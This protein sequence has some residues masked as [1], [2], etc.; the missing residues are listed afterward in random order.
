[1]AALVAETIA[2]TPGATDQGMTAAEALELGQGVCQDHAQVLIAVARIQGIPARYVTGYLYADASGEA[3]EASHAWA[4]LFVPDLGWVGFDPA[5]ACSPDDR[6]IRVGSGM[7][8]LDAAPIRG[9]I[10]GGGDEKMDIQLSVS[11]QQ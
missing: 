7:D 11:A 4:E 3:H 6:Y 10:L 5:N 1:M 2:Y 9:I 8:A